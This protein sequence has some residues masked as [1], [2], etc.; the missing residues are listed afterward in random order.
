MEFENNFDPDQSYMISGTVTFRFRS[1][2]FLKDKTCI[3]ITHQLQYLT[4]IDQI[5]L[6]DNVSIKCRR[7]WDRLVTGLGFFGDQTVAC[8]NFYEFLAHQKRKQRL[9]VYPDND[10]GRCHNQHQ[11]E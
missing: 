6:M 5:V 7:N 10:Y 9:T 3:L 4:A 8:L 2:G 1:T 11:S